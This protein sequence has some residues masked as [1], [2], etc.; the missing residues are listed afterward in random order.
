MFKGKISVT[1]KDS[2]YV[3]VDYILYPN[4]GHGVES[5]TKQWDLYK[6]AN[7]FTCNKVPAVFVKVAEQFQLQ[8]TVCALLKQ[9]PG[10]VLP[11]HA[12]RYGTYADRNNVTDKSKIRRIIVFLHKQIPGHQLWIDDVFCKGD[13]GSYFGWQNDTVHM[14]ANL[15]SKD[16]YTLQIT[17]LD[18]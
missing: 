18:L 2:D 17:G 11:F 3:D 12:D 16:R 1:W 13:A 9:R 4:P 8:N 5:K 14:A 10:Q 6:D 15:G 7:H